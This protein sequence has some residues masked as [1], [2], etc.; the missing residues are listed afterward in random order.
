[1]TYLII[2]KD[3]QLGKEFLKFFDKSGNKYFAFNHKELDI[4]NLNDVISCFEA[5]KPE[6]VINASAYNQVDLAEKNFDEA[7]RSNALGVHN[8]LFAGKKFNSLLIHFSTD[9]VFDGKKE[10][11]LYTELD[12]VN[13]LSQYG[14]SKYLGEA[15]VMK[16]LDNSLLFRTSW[17]FGDGKQNFIY[18]FLEWSNKNNILKVTSD[19]VSIPTHTK[20][21]VD[22][23][24]KAIEQKVR[25]L[26][27]LT[28]SSYCSRYELA[29][30][31]TNSLNL[32][33]IVYPVPIASFNLPAKRPEFSPMDNKKISDLLGISIPS[34]QESVKD[35]VESL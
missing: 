1:M 26:F 18:K 27:H 22:V 2:G 6:I 31:I 3:G 19:E 20:I 13:P 28:S 8:L 30:F 12:S 17:V 34:W 35:Y 14:K 4:S 11:G 7:Y 25:G 15:F 24:L 21:I 9:Y 29:K 33:N 16:S 5:I 23:T 32:K 10:N